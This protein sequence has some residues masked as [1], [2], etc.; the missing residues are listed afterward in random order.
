MLDAL[1]ITALAIYLLCFAGYHGTYFILLKKCP[2]RAVKAYINKLREDGIEYMI[3]RG[4]QIVV[5][6]ALRDA[7][8]VCN[9]FASSTLIF[10]GAIL[11]L[12]INMDKLARNM[13]VWNLHHFQFK[14]L[15]MV[16]VLSVSFIFLVSAL[17]YYRLVAVLVMAPPESIQKYTGEPAHRY[18]GKALN[19]GCT[20]YTLGSRGLIY[21]LLILL[22]LVN[23]EAFVAVVVGI[24][25]LLA[26]YR[27]FR[28]KAC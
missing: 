20:Y 22:W 5:V 1:N 28:H 19:S 16:G 9:L 8:M 3:K 7:I 27:D 11:N 12:L 26:K 2:H 13:G 14:I 4:D 10:I 6:Q 17:R 15:F 23:T 25:I 24:T 21:S 18:L